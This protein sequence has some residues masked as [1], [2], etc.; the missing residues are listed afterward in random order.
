MNHATA[1]GDHGLQ[2][3]AGIHLHHPL[4]IFLVLVPF[5]CVVLL[6]AASENADGDYHWV[7]VFGNEKNG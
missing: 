2:K 5:S 3:H 4:I 1:A 6:V 7:M